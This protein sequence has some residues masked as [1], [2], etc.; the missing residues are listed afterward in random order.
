M[1]LYASIQV[2]DLPEKA[3]TDTAYWWTLHWRANDSTWYARASL[4]PT[5]KWSFDFGFYNGGFNHLADVPGELV[6]DAIDSLS[7]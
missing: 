2:A 5:G 1:N 6:R 4:D 3:P 7:E